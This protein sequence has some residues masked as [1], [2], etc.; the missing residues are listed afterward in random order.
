MSTPVVLAGV[1]YNIPAYQD[2][3]Y[4][5]GTGNLSSY[6]IALASVVITS[7]GGTVPLTADLNFGTSFGLVALY[8]KSVSSNISTSGIL[9]LA[10]TD[11]I[12]W[13]NFGN[14]GN[15]VLGVNS[16][17]QLIYNGA[18]VQT[19]SGFVN[20]ITGTANEIIASSSTG[21]VTL[22]TPQ[23][24]APASSPTF[25]GLTV[26]GLTYNT[27]VITNGSDALA[28]S[29]TTA[30]ELSYVHGVTSPIQA[31]IN[32]ITSGAPS[33][34]I[35]MFG[36]SSA[37]S[38][39]LLCNGAAVSR[40]TYSTLFGVIGTTFGPGDG[41]TTFNVPNMVNW[42]P[43]GAGS[44]AALGANAGSETVNITDPGHNHTQNAHAH[45]ENLVTNGSSTASLDHTNFVNGTAPYSNSVTVD[46]F[47]SG[48]SYSATAIALT[49]NTTATN[50]SNTTGITATALPPVLGVTFIIKT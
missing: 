4:A 29:S 15:D 16:F 23:A 2:V 14:T 28:S 25:V 22:S 20:S 47:A 44:T 9:R 49:S 42:L 5:Q 41:S 17:D 38:G 39:W 3:G 18:V 10:N 32:A 37:P 1:T 6:L 34:A 48:G 13:R 33:G 50:N 36:A 11:T 43:I 45:E 7:G 12:G 21:A 30:T 24:I 8:Y 46:T 40:T 35:S 26:S 31:Q 27:A 19:G